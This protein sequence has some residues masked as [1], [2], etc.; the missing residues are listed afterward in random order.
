MG[1]IKLLGPGLPTVRQV[2]DA[3]VITRSA[4]GGYVWDQDSHPALRL[5]DVIWRVQARCDQLRRA[6]DEIDAILSL[7]PQDPSVERINRLLELRKARTDD[8]AFI[9]NFLSRV[10]PGR[11]AVDLGRRHHL[12]RAPGEAGASGPDPPGRS[13]GP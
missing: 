9:Q 4:T 2:D 7:S 11:L 8:L 5:E 12:P 3:V 1:V 6:V 10:Q 13:E